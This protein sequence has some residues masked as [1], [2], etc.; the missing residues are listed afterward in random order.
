MQGF[1]R[2]LSGELLALIASHGGDAASA[3]G[4]DLA[5]LY[6]QKNFVASSLGFFITSFLRA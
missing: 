3:L 5:V 2:G 1:E 6:G 4:L